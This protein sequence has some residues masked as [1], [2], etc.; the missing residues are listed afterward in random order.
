MGDKTEGVGQLVESES[1]NATSL[2]R[3]EK[4]KGPPWK[5]TM[6]ERRKIRALRRKE[7][8]VDLTDDTEDGSGGWS[9]GSRVQINGGEYSGGVGILVGPAGKKGR[10]KVQL[11]GIGHITLREKRLS[12]VKKRLSKHKFRNP[13]DNDGKLMCACGEYV[14][15][16]ETCFCKVAIC[17]KC[18]K[19]YCKLC[20]QYMCRSCDRIK[21]TCSICTTRCR[22]C[23]KGWTI[24]PSCRHDLCHSCGAFQLCPGICQEKICFKCRHEM[25]LNCK[26]VLESTADELKPQVILAP[27]TVAPETFKQPV[28]EMVHAV[29]STIALGLT[30][31]APLGVSSA[32]PVAVPAAIPPPPPPRPPPP[33]PPAATPVP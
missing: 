21:N 6:E 8:A 32:A 2:P 24:C 11:K 19:S 29:P 26:Y 27:N 25:C 16:L 5:R 10:W 15:K 30:A 31:A 20:E 7:M 28:G 17:D 9:S 18:K 4:R 3:G 33:P 1:T 14:D 22:R 13:R 12:L 23:R